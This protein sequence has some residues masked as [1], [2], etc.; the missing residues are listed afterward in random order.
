M[1]IVIT[2]AK[3]PAIGG[4]ITVS[5]TAEGKERI[6]EVTTEINGFAEPTDLVNP[7]AKFYENTLIQKGVF[8]G[9]NEV[10]VTAKDEHG[11]PTVAVK[12]WDS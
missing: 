7:P 1:K 9:H 5:V 3:N 8:P 12:K 11:N 2:P 4:D 6:A 10:V